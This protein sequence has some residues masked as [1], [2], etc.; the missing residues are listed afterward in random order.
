[1][2]CKAVSVRVD[3]CVLTCP[4][5]VGGRGQAPEACVGRCQRL[6]QALGEE[7][8][9]SLPQATVVPLQLAVVL[10]LV[11]PYQRLVLPQG[12]LTPERQGRAAG[13]QEQASLGVG[14]GPWV[15][16]GA[17]LESDRWRELREAWL[18]DR[19]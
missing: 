8:L 13:A 16:S 10:L 18:H 12:V 6:G 7:G 17:T 5:V 2:C 14:G 3:A 9:Q 4:S 15:G 19:Q 1:M 11:W